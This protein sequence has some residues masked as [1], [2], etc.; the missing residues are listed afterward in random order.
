MTNIENSGAVRAARQL[1]RISQLVIKNFRSVVD[2]KVELKPLTILV[3]GNSA[4]KSTLHSV[5]RLFVQAQ[6]LGVSDDS[7]PLNGPLLSMGDFEELLH[8]GTSVEASSSITIGMSFQFPQSP[9]H[10]VTEPLAEALGNLEAQLSEFAGDLRTVQRGSRR[11]GLDAWLASP[12]SISQYKQIDLEIEL[13]E[14]SNSGSSG[15]RISGARMFL[16]PINDNGRRVR[17]EISNSV[18]ETSETFEPGLDVEV[19]ETPINL[20]GRIE[21]LV[22][23]ASDIEIGGAGFRGG[24]PISV[25]EKSDIATVV[26]ND[27][28]QSLLFNQLT[29]KRNDRLKSGL[30]KRPELRDSDTDEKFVVDVMNRILGGLRQLDPKFALQLCARRGDQTGRSRL[31]QR[32][33]IP[34]FPDSLASEIVQFFDENLDSLLNDLYETNDRWGTHAGMVIPELNLEIAVELSRYLQRKVSFL[35]GVRY[36]GTEI[37]GYGMV[38]TRG[39]IG[40]SGEYLTSV[41]FQERNRRIIQC[42]GLESRRGVTLSEALNHWIGEFEFGQSISVKEQPGYGYRKEIV[43]VGLRKSVSLRAV[44][45]G[46]DHAIPVIVRVLTARPGD[47][48]ILEQPEIHLH[49]DAQLKMADFLVSAVMTGRNIVVETHSELFALRIRRLIAT[50]TDADRDELK[51]RIGFIFA[52]RDIQTAVSTYKNVELSDD[53]GFEDWP[54]GFFD[55]QEDESLAIL[56]ATLD[57]EN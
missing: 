45:R 29:S 41:L 14:S 51:S 46:V 39:D 26:L 16:I 7:F 30:K 36:Q 13:T 11:T 27:V 31:A 15:T 1:P 43:P 40:T 33:D 21:G 53:G 18:E 9:L 10:G 20:H 4:G 24:I 2:Q 49:P 28:R 44:G 19:E 23:T 3:G 35:D 8:A 12:E 54:A 34:R 42:P 47:L 56:Q 32:L 22:R 17:I 48:V 55:Q 52:E 5:L 6:S 57:V 25:H 37:Q 38:G 50:A